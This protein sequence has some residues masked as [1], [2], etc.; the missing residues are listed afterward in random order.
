MPLSLD[1]VVPH[2]LDLPLHRAI[3]LRL[4]DPADPTAGLALD[5]DG[6]TVNPSGVLHGG[7]VPLVLDVA[8]YL[9]LVPQLPAG[10][11]GA[12]TV[13][14]TVSLLT[15][16]PAGGSVVAAATVERCGRTTA[17]VSTRLTHG[18]RLVATGQVVKAILT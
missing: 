8:A 17:F 15:A 13:S 7:L 12:V 18:D 4:H 11:S 2:V 6:R 3:G 14:S 1:D 5:V 10:A 16:V 9:A